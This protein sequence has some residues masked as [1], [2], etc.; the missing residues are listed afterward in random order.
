LLLFFWSF[1]IP[2]GGCGSFYAIHVSST[3]FK[4]L[5]T[6]KQHKLVNRCLEKEV[7]EIHGLQVRSCSGFSR[8]RSCKDMDTD[9]LSH[10]VLRIFISNRTH[11]TFFSWITRFLT[12]I[13]LPLRHRASSR[14]SSSRPCPRSKSEHRRSEMST[15]EFSPTGP[16][17]G[18]SEPS[19]QHLGQKQNLLEGDCAYNQNDPLSD[20]IYISREAQGPTNIA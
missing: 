7:K 8:L 2:S 5:S 13:A 14:T 9:L 1:L 19:T 11:E 3:Q 20:I 6:I 12:S 10:H 15:R 16:E 18:R 17:T 4:G